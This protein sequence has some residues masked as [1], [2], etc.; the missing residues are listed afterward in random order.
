[1]AKELTIDKM[2]RP[3]QIVK[4]CTAFAHPYEVATVSAFTS[5]T[6]LIVAK[7]EKILLFSFPRLSNLLELAEREYGKILDRMVR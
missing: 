5:F 4:R 6:P 1:V 3:N 2:H 7:Q